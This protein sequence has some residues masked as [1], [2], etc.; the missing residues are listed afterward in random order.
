MASSRIIFLGKQILLGLL[1]SV[2]FVCCSL[3]VIA[4]LAVLLP[5]LPLM[6]VES[7]VF[8]SVLVLCVLSAGGMVMVLTWTIFRPWRSDDDASMQFTWIRYFMAAWFT[9]FLPLVN[10]MFMT[11]IMVLFCHVLCIQCVL[12]AFFDYWQYSNV[13]IQYDKVSLI[14]L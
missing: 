2:V 11:D 12:F 9:A 14:N 10:Y 7:F 3:L 8:F 4:M 5:L 6:P 1:G 13:R